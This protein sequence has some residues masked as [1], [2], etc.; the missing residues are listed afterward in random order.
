M[1]RLII[2]GAGDFGREVSWVAERMNAQMP[3]WELLGFVD[4]SNVMRGKSVDGYPVLG[5]VSY[6]ETIEEPTYVVCSIGTGYIRKKVM[7]QVLK[8][9]Y[10]Q[11]AT[12]IDPAVVIGRNVQIEPGCVICAGTVL[13]ISCRI[14]E[15][16]I[17]NLNCTIGHDT[18]LEPYCTVHPGSNLS[19]RVHVGDCT[20]IGTGTK[21]IQGLSVCP[22]CIIGAG[23]VVVKNITEPGTYV[24]VPARRIK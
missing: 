21:I 23:S 7:E 18:V 19:G 15:N 2:V 13:A 8:N 4:D 17:V 5:P 14:S 12:L 1:K 10:L 9:P 20:D 24:G 3:V 6:L 16:S 22:G 11:P